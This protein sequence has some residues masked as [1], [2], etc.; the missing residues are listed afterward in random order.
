MSAVILKAARDSDLFCVWE[1]IVDNYIEIGTRADIAMR[2]PWPD[3]PQHCRAARLDRAEATGTSGMYPG[4]H[5]WD[6]P[7]ILV[8]NMQTLPGQRLLARARL[9]EYLELML[10][11]EVARAERLTEAIT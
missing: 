9:A 11:G 6:E 3:D 5:G 2:D 10:V 1:S 4:A 8:S 7:W